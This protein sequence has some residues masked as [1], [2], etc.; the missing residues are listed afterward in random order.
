MFIKTRMYIY[1]FK[2]FLCAKALGMDPSKEWG[3]ME[4]ANG[5]Y[6]AVKSDGDVVAYFLYDHSK[7]EQYL[8][9]NTIFERASTGKHHFASLYKEN[10]HMYINL[11]LDIRFKSNR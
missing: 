5:G 1:K 10:D 7:F 2:K 3:G 6:I 9:D 8:L 4:E 11:N